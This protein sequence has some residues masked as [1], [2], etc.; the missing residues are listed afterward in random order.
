MWAMQE[1][2]AKEFTLSVKPDT[3]K[4]MPSGGWNTVVPPVSPWAIQQQSRPKFADDDQLKKQ[5][6]IEW[7][8]VE[9]PF[10]AACKIFKTDTSAA[11]WI[12]SNWLTDP[13]VNAAKD[14]YLKEIE[15]Q[16][17]LLDKDA[18]AAML[19]QTAM[20]TSIEGR[21]LIEAKERVNLLKLYADVR[22]FLNKD[23][24]TINNFNNNEG[25]KV[26]FV[27][28]EL[29]P[30]ALAPRVVSNSKSE[31]LNDGPSPLKIKLVSNG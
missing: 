8:K 24:A 13:I 6:G 28:A 27:K 1:G 17:A 31:I 9:K 3:D 29:Q 16:A 11:L 20:E 2:W 18:F 30:A 5:F 26:V 4:F 7:G 14:V 12:A 19:M 22:G 21:Y 15:A 25:L 23:S 10:E